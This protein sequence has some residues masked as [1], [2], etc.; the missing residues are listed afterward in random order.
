[1]KAPIKDLET[2]KRLLEEAREKMA[3]EAWE[4][5]EKAAREALALDEHHA[6]A[7]DLMG[8]IFEAREMGEEAEQWREKAKLVRRQAWQRQVEAE[9]R[10]HHEMLGAPGRH[11]IP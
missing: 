4:E 6:P 11:E 7:Y 2:V 5:A 3:A 8:E 1:M 9:A 10:G